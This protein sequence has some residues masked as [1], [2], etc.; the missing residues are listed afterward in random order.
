MSS[1]NNKLIVKNTLVLYA[2]MLLTVVI[3]LYTGR[4]VLST[5]G[6][7]D[8]GIY[9]I[10]GGVVSSLWFITS[11]LASTSTRYL[12]YGLG[13]GDLTELKKTFGN[14]CT[15][16]YALA[17]IILVFA[18]TIGIWF[19]MNKLVI[20]P[21]RLTAAIWVYHFSVISFLLAI[22]SAPYN[23]VIIAHEKMKVYAYINLWN[24]IL[25]LLIVY[26]IMISPFDKLIFYA[27]LLLCVSFQDRLIYGIYCLRHFEE[28]KAHL[29]FNKQ[30]FK[31]LFSYASWM[32]VGNVAVMCS[33]E[34]FNIL[35]NLFY[36][37]VVNAARGL[38]VLIQGIVDSLGYQFQTAMK[39]QIIKNYAE[40]DQEHMNFLIFK[41]AKFSFFVTFAASLPVMLEIHQFLGWW[42][43][44][45][46]QWTT[47]FT[48][49]VLAMSCISV[50]GVSLY[51]AVSATGSVKAYQTG[52][53]LVLL[54]FLP[55]TYVVLKFT[56]VNPVL[57]FMIQ[58]VFCIISSAVSAVI[59]LRQLQISVSDYLKHTVIPI[60]SVLILSS[61]LPLMLR[62]FL[63]D[64][65]ASF[66]I[67]CAV[68][69]ISVL[70]MS[71]VI[72]CNHNEREVIRTVISKRISILIAR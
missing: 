20:P 13:K 19:V 71:Y 3:G 40:G 53:A 47:Q 42:L 46:P 38:A 29:R 51:N 65:F 60:L 59:A 7:V 16:H 4:I 8:Y 35:L 52:Q 64:N 18:E 2:Q 50:V 36:G 48:I 25:K 57:P 43:V 32:C 1:T 63:E 31:E 15:V 17:A 27:F 11:A 62:V 37:P 5:L 67:V 70:L 12:I 54:S 55:V 72:G 39:P 26:M 10:A 30:Q 41:G 21:E 44:E 68:S 23:G 69:V 49:I 14:I 28:S 61:I 66:L 9:N 58:F 45:V 24:C 33:R 6:V 56:S 34:G 22:I